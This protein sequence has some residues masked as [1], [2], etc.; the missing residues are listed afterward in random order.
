MQ[1]SANI[2]KKVKT[3]EEAEIIRTIDFK[4]I[5]LREAQELMEWFDGYRLERLNELVKDYQLIGD[6]YL[7]S[8]EGATFNSQ[9]CMLTEM[10]PYYKYWERK[11]FNAITKMIIRALAVV[12]AIL[13]SRDGVKPLIRMDAGNNNL[14]IIY[15]PPQ[16]EMQNQLEKFHKN[17]ID[18][19]KQFG[20]WKDKT[21]K[22]FPYV[23]DHESTEKI[24]KYTFY[25]D[26][27]KNPVI[28]SLTEDN[29][30]QIK[31][32][33]DKFDFYSTHLFTF[34]LLKSL[35]DMNRFNHQHRQMEKHLVDTFTVEQNIIKFREYKR[36]CQSLIGR[37]QQ[38]G[39]ILIDFGSV[40]S[41][42]VK[43]ADLWLEMMGKS[44]SE[45]AKSKL[46]K[47]LKTI[48]DWET[49]FNVE[50]DY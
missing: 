20:R 50:P 6:Q 25:D 11:V 37:T 30:H 47:I 33:V 10:L 24:I 38:N 4:T 17:I 13:M 46:N 36:F 27:I 16:E 29:T 8:I 18:S 43:Q 23:D 35:Y 44:L 22:V 1:Q 31:K 42:A 32:L 9:T 28:I 48:K 2:E 39:P 26:V 7:K 49:S 19:T 3:I 45:N 15:Q 14:E 41:N 5:Q 40:Y 34:P 21:C 12:K